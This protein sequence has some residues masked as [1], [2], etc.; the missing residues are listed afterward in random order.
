M[1]FSVLSLFFHIT[2]TFGVYT[3]HRNNQE[4]NEYQM[5]NENDINNIPT[6]QGT[7]HQAPTTQGP[8]NTR[9][10]IP[11]IY[12]STPAPSTPPPSVPYGFSY[13]YSQKPPVKK[14]KSTGIIAV[15]AVI[16]GFSIIVAVLCLV[17]TFHAVFNIFVNQAGIV[18]WIGSLIPLIVI[19]VYL[20]FIR[21][22]VGMI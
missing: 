4:R 10:Q 2:I 6:D 22:R 11:P 21:S 16:A 20:I 17:V 9:G 8:E 5:F 18:F 14:S 1:F 15:L 12:P 13:D 19:L 7:P 3:P